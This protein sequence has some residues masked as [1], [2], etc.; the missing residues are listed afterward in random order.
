MSLQHLRNMA[1]Y[2]G[3]SRIMGQ[4]QTAFQIDKRDNVATALVQL[5]PGLVTLRGDTVQS[6]V[7]VAEEIPNGHKIALRYI[8]EGEEITKYGVCIGRA[9]TDIPAGSWVH[10]H[11]MRSLYDERSSHLDVDTGIPRDTKYE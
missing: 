4:T 7:T 2:K 8:R 6:V 9:T 1:F 10:L 11:V 5:A 3:E